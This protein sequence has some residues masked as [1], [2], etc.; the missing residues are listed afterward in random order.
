M[1][2]TKS[3]RP[4][5][6][7]AWARYIARATL[8][9]AA[10]SRSRFRTEKF[11]ERF[12]QEARAIAALN[13][14]NICHL[15]DVGPNY[16]VMELIEGATL[17]GP[18]P[19]E[20]ALGYARQILDALDA[21]HQKGIT[22]RDLKPANILVTKSG[23]KLLDF[24][25]AKQ[26]GPLKETDATQALTERGS[27]VGTLN[28]MS[29]EQLQ[30]KEADARSDVFS[31]GLVLYEMLTG[32]RAFEGTNAAS[33]IAAILERTTPS[34]AGVA[35]PALDRILRRTLAKQP[36][37]RWQSALDI[38]HAIDDLEAESPM[39]PSPARR[40]WPLA[41]GLAA[42]AA[43][44][45]L[46]LTH[47]AGVPTEPYTLSISAPPGVSLEFGIARGG[48]ALSPDGRTVAFATQEALWVRSLGSGELRK[49]P[50][51]DRAYYPF[52]SP[53]G[54]FV[55][56]FSTRSLM[57]VE[58]TS[59]VLTEVTN[60]EG[61]ARGG[62]WGQDGTILFALLNRAIYRVPSSGGSPEPATTLDAARRESAHYYP[63]FLPDGDRFL[64]G[65]RARDDAGIFAGSLKD[66][67]VRIKVAGVLSNATFV[68]ASQGQPAY[69]L[70]CRDGKLLAQPVNSSSLQSE[71]DPRI[72]GDP[73]VLPNQSMANF[74]SARNGT[75]VVGSAGSRKN[76]LAWFDNAGSRLSLLGS[77]DHLFG[78]R[79]SPDGARVTLQRYVFGGGGGV[80]V[81]DLARGINLDLGP[82]AYPFW[83]PDGEA[84]IYFQGTTI[85][86]KG[87][88]SV[89][90]PKSLA[91]LQGPAQS[92]GDISPDGNYVAVRDS[93]GMVAIPL[94]QSNRAPIIFGDGNNPRFS[95][96]GRYVAYVGSS[97]PGIYVENFPQRT[98]R[99]VVANTGG[100]PDWARDA[101]RLY[102]R[103]HEGHLVSVDIHE[104]ANGLIFG[105]PHEVFRLPDA[106]E[107]VSA[108]YAVSPDGKQ[109]L[110]FVEDEKIH[111]ENEL[112]VLLNWR[113][114]LKR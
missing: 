5:E 96:D 77:P 71:G 38:K 65:V 102:Y 83:S 74:A 70:Y 40:W 108:G 69:V 52:F 31:F 3:S 100:L 104:S 32:K 33:V 105:S 81:L 86:R 16:L 57:K 18:L 68:P 99:S 17:K 98:F 97:K 73:G 49:L 47:R 6:R 58:L 48:I 114:A 15:Y 59:G 21:A 66:P 30:S 92:T 54:R 22:H 24:G 62:T 109:F 28:Y 91:E 113:E 1:A 11:T 44:A 56:Y 51:T 60:L 85:M 95:P 37:D 88:D 39:K 103:S 10:M 64:Y 78:P 41:L 79:M 26:S 9:S 93:R 36:E 82:G 27:I 107:A 23:I 42:L 72:L 43:A 50:V 19:V 67:H 101:K 89:A 55:A 110:S 25:L 12:E 63:N 46:A 111:A 53:D 90:P 4:S 76:Q 20:K 45:A 2:L 112:T 35:P 13:H 94:G 80:L 14:P 106:A 87:A 8:A 75:V 34:I 84:V 61:Q 7:A 29:P